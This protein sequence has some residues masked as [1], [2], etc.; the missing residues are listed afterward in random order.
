MLLERLGLM[1]R[2]DGTVQRCSR[3]VP[4]D[5]RPGFLARR[6]CRSAD[7]RHIPYR[8]GIQKAVEE[9]DAASK[10]YPD[11]KVLLSV[12]ASVLA[13]VGRA[14]DAAAELKKLLDG[15]ND[16]E[17]YISLAQVYEKAKNYTEMAKAIDAADKLVG[18]EGG[19]RI[20]RFHARR[21][22]R[23]DEEVRCRRDRVP[24]SSG[25]E[26][27]ERFRAELSGLHARRP[28]YRGLAKPWTLS[29]KRSNS[30]RITAPT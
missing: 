15:K 28:Q 19:K 3:N 22:V 18:L 29:S 14:D 16:R 30:T 12:R 10:K 6:P 17:T 8:K 7:Y 1:Y 23:K 24:Q 4:P 5:R 25:A 26:S 20:D 2:G 21:D 9:A 13:E 27:K 11:D